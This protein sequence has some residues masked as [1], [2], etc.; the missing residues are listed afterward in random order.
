[1]TDS[2]SVDPVSIGVAGAVLLHVQFLIPG[3]P[4]I[5]AL[6]SGFHAQAFKHQPGHPQVRKGGVADAQFAARHCCQSDE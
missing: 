1:M 3:H 6:H 2:R 5:L 4:Q